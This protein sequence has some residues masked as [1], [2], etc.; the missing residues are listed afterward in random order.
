M[1]LRQLS[2][3]GLY[4]V[5][6]CLAHFICL[7]NYPA[8]PLA[9]LTQLRVESL[10]CLA[11]CHLQL[12]QLASVDCLSLPLEQQEHPQL[13]GQEKMEVKLGPL[14]FLCQPGPGAQ[15]GEKTQF[16]VASLDCQFSDSSSWLVLQ[17]SCRLAYR[18]TLREE[19]TLTA[20]PGSDYGLRLFLAALLVTFIFL[21][22]R[23]HIILTT[24]KVNRVPTIPLASQ[25]VAD[26]KEMA[27]TGGETERWRRE[28]R[29]FR[30][31]HSAIR[32]KSRARSRSR[33]R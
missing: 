23:D 26:T 15:L 2:L 13:A 27:E 14:Q 17:S 31:N 12:S 3:S 32:D 24:S 4:A 20:S 30:Q 21:A 10:E 28:E 5:T 7:T 11:G 22:L 1:S 33:R 16:E 18:L 8:T 9:D 19:A 25:V 6:L 29:H